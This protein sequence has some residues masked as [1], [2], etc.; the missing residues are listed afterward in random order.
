MIVLN[1]QSPIGDGATD[2][3]IGVNAI[4]VIFTGFVFGAAFLNGNIIVVHSEANLRAVPIP[5]GLTV[6]AL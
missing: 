6:L 5:A 4:H 3:G 2:Q 1:E